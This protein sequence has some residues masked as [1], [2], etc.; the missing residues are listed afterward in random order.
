MADGA[1]LDMSM[2]REVAP[3]SESVEQPQLLHPE[4]LSV[5]PQPD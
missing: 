4:G 1:L 3:G 2:L 5:L